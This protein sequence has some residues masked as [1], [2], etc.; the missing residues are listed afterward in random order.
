MFGLIHFLKLLIVTL[1]CGKTIFQIG[2]ILTFQPRIDRVF[3]DSGIYFTTTITFLVFNEK[4]FYVKI[5]IFS[6]ISSVD[7]HFKLPEHYGEE[8]VYTP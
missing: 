7:T 4:G 5:L 1:Q 6:F 8:K 3:Q 2:H